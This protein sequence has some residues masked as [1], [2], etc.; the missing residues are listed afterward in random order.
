[1]ARFAIIILVG[2][3]VACTPL[4]S[5]QQLTADCPTQQSVENLLSNHWL[6][7]DNVWRLR[8]SA[9]LELGRRKIPLEGFLRL[10]L[11]RSEAR[12][13][14][15]NEMGLVM[16]DLQLDQQGQVLNRAI[17]Q[18]QKMNGFAKGIAQSLRQ[19]FLQPQPLSD[20]HVEMAANSQRLWRTIPD[21]SVGFTFD[22]LGDLRTTRLNAE[23]GDW[24]VAYD[25]YRS[26]GTNRLPEQ[27][28]LNDYRSGIKLTLWMREVK[29][30]P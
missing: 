25:Q 14:A 11:A 20:D 9:L 19:I 1:M 30:E 17:P 8:Q 13:L 29:Q 5:P 18:L 4:T 12:L 15:M 23:Q 16:F 6:Q 7:N 27:I 21:G 26:F 10:D 24:R 3:L 22:C 2:L 28:T